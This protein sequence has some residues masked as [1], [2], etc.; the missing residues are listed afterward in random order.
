MEFICRM[1]KLNSKSRPSD[2]SC[3]HQRPGVRAPADS[4]KQVEMREMANLTW[5]LQSRKWIRISSSCYGL[6]NSCELM[7]DLCPAPPSKGVCSVSPFL[8]NHVQGEPPESRQTS[9]AIVSNKKWKN[10]T[11]KTRLYLYFSPELWLGSGSCRWRF[12]VT[13]TW[14]RFGCKLPEGGDLKSCLVCAA[15]FE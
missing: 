8:Q 6:R 10:K 5:F 2:G 13:F 14:S 12:R 11:G 15:D 4:Q 9:K 1:G 3:G 7:T